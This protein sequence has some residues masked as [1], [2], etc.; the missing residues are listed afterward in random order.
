ML[1][2]HDRRVTIDEIQQRVAEHW[3]IR[4]TEMTSP[5]APAPSPGRARWRCI[6][7]SSSPAA[8][9]PEIGRE[10]RQPR[11]HDRDARRQRAWPS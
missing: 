11:P 5:A 8:A 2:A 10:I 3:N 1:K 9:L 7:R 6:W 4:L